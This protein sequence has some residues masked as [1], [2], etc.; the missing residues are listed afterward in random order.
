MRGFDGFFLIQY[1]ITHNM[2]PRQVILNGT[3]LITCIV[4]HFRMRIVDSLN[5]LPMTLAEMPKAFNIN[6]D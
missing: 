3:K 1:L 5:F 2:K 4:P 6:E